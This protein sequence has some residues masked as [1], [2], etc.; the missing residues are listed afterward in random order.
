MTFTIDKNLKICT[1]LGTR[2]EIIKLSPIIPLLEQ[3]T[4]HF[5]IHT[6]QHYDFEMDQVFFK[7]LQLPQPKYNLN[8]GSTT[9]G[10]QIAAILEKVE[11]IFILEKPDL[12]VVLGD[13]NTVSATAIAAAHLHIPLIHLEAGCRSFN[14]AMPEE[15]NRIIADHLA[16][17]LIA[18]DEVSVENLKNEGLIKNVFMLGSTMFDAIV[19]NKQFA[20]EEKILLQFSLEKNNFILVTLHRAENTDNLQNL[21]N[22]IAALNKLADEITLV[23]PIHPRTK[24]ALLENHL[25]LNPKI[26]IL[27][28]QSYLP[29]LGLLSGCLFCMSDSGGIQEEALVCNKPCLILRN[30][31]EWTRLVTAGKNILTTTNTAQILAVAQE[32]L[33]DPAKLK[34]IQDIQYPYEIGVAQKIMKVINT[35]KT[36]KP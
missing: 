34:A 17:Y 31:T 11:K 4:E 5:I 6:G 28:P 21:K 13:T 18:P 26:R 14:R 20:E 35:A 36:T 30:E 25:S 1:V 10:M 33:R 22:I 24:K 12:I 2:P 8:I 19:R 15:T 32:L 27:G 7:E 16:T 9:T 3:T 23:F 29:F